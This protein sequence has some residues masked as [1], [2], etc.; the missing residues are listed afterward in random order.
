[1]AIQVNKKEEN[2]FLQIDIVVASQFLKPVE[3]T[4]LIKEYRHIS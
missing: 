2:T 1:M 4:I 3:E